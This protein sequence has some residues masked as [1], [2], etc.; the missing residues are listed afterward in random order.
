M[1][2]QF[3]L[4]IWKACLSANEGFGHSSSYSFPTSVF[5]GTTGAG[6]D[7]LQE[8]THW[9]PPV[10]QVLFTNNISYCGEPNRDSSYF[11]GALSSTFDC[12]FVTT[13]TYSASPQ[14]QKNIFFFPSLFSGLLKKL[15][16]T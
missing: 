9:E 3:L 7:D 12:F 15:R 1:S 8:T 11:T 6:E 14:H 13:G 16:I 5:N 10:G 2:M 4:R